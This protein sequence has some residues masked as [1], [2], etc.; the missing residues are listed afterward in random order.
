[1]PAPPELRDGGGHIGQVEVLRIAET[2][3]PADADGHIRI[4]GEVKIDL[5]EE[6][7][8]RQPRTE[9]GQP[10]RVG[11]EVGN[12][13]ARVIR[14][15]HL[16]GKTGGKAQ[17]AVE[18]HPRIRA[19]LRQLRSD[20]LIA[21]D[22]ALRHFRE[23]ADVQQEIREALRAVVLPAV[24]VDQI[25]QRLEGIEGNAQR[26]RSRR[27]AEGGT[28]QRIQALRQRAQRRQQHAS[29]HVKPEN[30]EQEIQIFE[31]SQRQK[32]HAHRDDQELAILLRQQR[33][34]IVVYIRKSQ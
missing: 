7:E 32:V 19:A 12:D 21:H 18:D 23:H 26:Q 34:E 24:D 31:Q 4:A 13:L 17:D 16:L 25:G 11:S 20:L 29:L 10:R 2:E 8:G 30:A 27:R 5:E 14:Q 33:S 15:Q 6:Q 3:D 1:M 28:E 22:R 9:E